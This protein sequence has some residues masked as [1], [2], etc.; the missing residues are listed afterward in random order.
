MV[1]LAIAIVFLCVVFPTSFFW[2]PYL[3]AHLVKSEQM[4]W[5]GVMGGFVSAAVWCS[6][7]IR[8]IKPTPQ[9]RTWKRL[10]PQRIGF[11][12]RPRSRRK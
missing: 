9:T 10:K 3:A 6:I 2:I 4:M 5:L 7:Q 12:E 1:Q 8:R 11:L